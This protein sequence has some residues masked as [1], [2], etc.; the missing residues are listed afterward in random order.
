MIKYNAEAPEF[1]YAR[2]EQRKAQQLIN[3][4]EKFWKQIEPALPLEYA[5]LD[6]ELA[7]QYDKETRAS[8]LFDAFALITM[9]ISCLGL[10]GLATYSAERSVKEIGIRKVLGASVYE[11]V[12]LLTGDFVVLVLV[13][14]IIAAPLAA[15]VMHRWLEQYACRVSL[16]GWMF[17]VAGGMAV[18][19]TLI[20]VGWQAVRAAGVNPSDTL[21]SE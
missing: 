21:R 11:I 5:F 12:G 4:T 9:F 3:F 19:A 15:W 18:G 6:D 7:R 20:T 14:L 13:A 1:V 8:H 17:A 16:S 2:V 10:F